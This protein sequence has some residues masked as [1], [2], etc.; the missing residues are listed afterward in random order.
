MKKLAYILAATFAL[1]ACAKEEI[2]HPSEAQ[3]PKTASAFEPII[4]VDQEINQ[5]T[6]SVDSKAVI[7]V[8]IFQ[9]KDGEFTERKAQNGLRR[10]FATAGDY[11][12]R[13]QVMNASGV[14]PDYVEKTFHIDNTIA[15]FDKFITF[16]AGGTAADNT[17]DWHVDGETAGHMGCGP[18]GTDGLEWWSAAA[19]DKAAFG[20]YEDVVTFGGDGAYAYDPGEDGG[21]YVNKDITVSPFVEQKGD[22]TEDFVALVDP[23]TATYAFEYQGN[24]LYLVLPEK[25]LFPYIDNDAFWA[26][27]EFKVLSV[28]REALELVHD[29]GDIAWHFLLTS[30]PAAYVFKGFKYNA[31]SNLWK[32]ADGAHT[33]SFYYAPGWAQIADPEVELEGAEYTIDLPSATADQWQAQFHIVPEE[34]VV[35]TEDKNYDFSVIINTNKALPGMTFKLTSVDSDDVFLFANREPIEVGETIYYLSDL[36]GINAPNGVKMVF[37]FG[38]NAEGTVVSIANIV[39]KD[40]AIDDGTILPSDEPEDPEDGDNIVVIYG[41][42]LWADATVELETWFSP[43]DWS[44]GLDPQA[45]YAEGKLTLTVPEGTGG[46]E[47]Q[48]QVKLHTDIAIDPA[49][50][51]AFNAKFNAG[52]DGFAT[53]KMT[54]NTDPGGIEFFYDNNLELTAFEDYGYKQEGV[55]MAVEGETVMVVFDFGRLPAGTEVTVSDITLHEVQVGEVT[56]GDNIWDNNAELETWFSPADWSGGLDPQATYADGKL[57]LTVPE[58]TGG[59]EWQGQVK[60]HTN[61]AIDP[62]KLYGFSAKVNAGADGLITAKMTSNTDPGGIEFFYD[63]GIA[64]TAFEDVLIKKDKIQMATTEG[65]TIMVVFDFGRLPAGTEVTVTEITVRELNVVSYNETNIWDN[66]AELETWFS[67]ADWSGGLDPQATYTDGKLTLTVPEGTGGA[68]W[69]GQVKLH[70]SVPIESGAL[71]A[72]SFTINA[73]SDGVATAKMTSNT[74]PGGIEFFYDNGVELTAFE[75]LTYLQKGVSMAIGEGETVM[76]VLDFGRFPAG[77]EITVSDIVL[78]KAE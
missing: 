26:N 64:L 36:K 63:N 2:R 60:L 40:H 20:V 50:K 65:E 23:Q 73:S 25:T 69:Q 62:N 27:P 9:D 11:T 30:K 14:T 4:S 12:V 21:V 41:K 6:F 57:T 45:T 19:N 15:S 48:G 34:P 77:T 31:D 56:Y 47:W 70:T 10:I 22:A 28:T 13:M 44:G 76:L 29:N 37:D 72:V 42:E 51:Y 68:E 35:L 7:P 39:V 38:G 43:A 66:N 8:W 71:Y 32:P 52:S 59:A 49:K 55:S 17:K 1:F 58:G 16:L 53:A 24:D 5:V 33:F 61:I 54:S 67:P 46:A 18:A 78:L 74:D 3:A 75:N